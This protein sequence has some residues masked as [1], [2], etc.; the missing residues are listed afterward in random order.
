MAAIRDWARA[1]HAGHHPGAMRSRWVS[2]FYV[3]TEA[4]VG[5]PS[6]RASWSCW[7][8]RR[9]GRVSSRHVTCAPPRGP[10]VGARRTREGEVWFEGLVPFGCR[11]ACLRGLAC[12][13]IGVPVCGHAPV[14]RSTIDRREPNDVCTALSCV[15]RIF[16][17][18]A[19][20][21]DA[22]RSD[23]VRRS[24]G[25]RNRDSRCRCAL[26]FPDPVRLGPLARVL[27][28]YMVKP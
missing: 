11:R 7:S 3:G 28:W 19:V 4:C 13:A 26:A 10:V 15:A 17:A 6:P 25:S 5:E 1:V 2:R 8:A 20:R 27:A 22:D 9:G 23:S 24:T 21:P 16:R 18:D 14:G 12:V